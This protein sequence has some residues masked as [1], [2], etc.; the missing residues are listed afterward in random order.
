V[1]A[2]AL[3]ATPAGLAALRTLTGVTLDALEQGRIRRAGPAPAGGPARV[4]EA[5]ARAVPVILPGEGVGAE[6]A[7]RRIVEAVAAGAVDPADP[8]C[9]AHL[10]AAP[11]AV[12]AAADL[13]ASVLN[14]SLD[15]W[16]QAPAAG[17]LERLV[18]DAVADLVYPGA[19]RADALVTTGATESNLVALLLAREQHGPGIRVVCSAEAH[20]SVGRAAWLLGLA[21]PVA[22]PTTGGRM[23]VDALA[24]VLD[25]TPGP[26]FVVATAGTTDRG[27]IDPI[28]SIAEQARRRGAHLHV[29][30]AYGGGLL[31]GEHRRLL[32]GL[33]RADTVALDLH[34]LGWQPLPAGLL[35]VRESSALAPLSLVADYLNAND[36]QEAGFPDLLGRSI[37][38]SRRPDALKLAVTFQA[39]GRAGIARLTERCRL[40]AAD[41]ADAIARRADLR[42]LAHPEISTVLFRPVVADHLPAAEG[43]E[44]VA[45][46]RRVLLAEGSAVIG[47]A[48]IADDGLVWLKLTVLNPETGTVHWGRLLDLV[49]SAVTR[50]CAAPA[51]A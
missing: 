25:G 36:D 9:A 19:T 46:V 47:R 24:E 37:R 5:V 14:P 29:D 34:K 38:T 28:E 44:L 15:S 21:P 23:S 22:V 42:L 10:H 18:T 3:A 32:A 35:A 31:F 11:L 51:A 1:N 8:L 13:A 33:D 7:L 17:E 39:L 30:A 2:G 48:T 50:I 26:H 27:V 49:G 12:A 45:E 4:A 43:N 6:P 40:V 16:D 41:I 20:H